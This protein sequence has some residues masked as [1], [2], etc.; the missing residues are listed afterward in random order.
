MAQPLNSTVTGSASFSIQPQVTADEKNSLISECR[1]VKRSKLKWFQGD[2][3]TSLRLRVRPH[4]R[5]R[6]PK[7]TRCALS[8]INNCF[9]NGSIKTYLKCT[10]CSVHLSND[11]RQYRISC[12][13]EWHSSTQSY[14]R[15]NIQPSPSR[16]SLRS[17]KIENIQYVQVFGLVLCLHWVIS[18]SLNK[19]KLS[20]RCCGEQLLLCLRVIKSCTV[21]KSI[22]NSVIRLAVD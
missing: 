17:Y 11:P 7:C 15:T 2:R 21:V 14:Q 5:C 1:N 22:R 19:V 4:V 6:T 20:A 9:N 13:D 18:C 3:G 16:R 10:T 8:N 12:W